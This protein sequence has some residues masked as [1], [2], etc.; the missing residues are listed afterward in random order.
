M[1]ANPG[2]TRMTLGQLCTA[3]WDCQ[4]QLVVIQPRIEPGSIVTPLALR[5]SALDCCATRKPNYRWGS[6]DLY[7]KP[8][9][10]DCIKVQIGGST[11]EQGS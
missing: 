3:L 2:Q 1:T 7:I 11:P 6:L 8:I 4:S 10:L 5:C 9:A